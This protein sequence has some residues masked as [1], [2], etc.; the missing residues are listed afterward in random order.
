MRGTISEISAQ[1]RKEVKV[2]L[3]VSRAVK[4]VREHNLICD[5]VRQGVRGHFFWRESVR[6]KLVGVS[7]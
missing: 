4:E 3:S 5:R 1:E 7:S 2:R 6:Y